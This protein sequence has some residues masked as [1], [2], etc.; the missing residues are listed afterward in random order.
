MPELLGDL[1]RF[2]IR[3]Q[4]SKHGVPREERRVSDVEVEGPPVATV[5]EK[6]GMCLGLVKEET[7]LLQG[8]PPARIAVALII[9]VLGTREDELTLLHVERLRDHKDVVA[10][11]VMN[12]HESTTGMLRHL[13]AQ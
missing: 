5:G 2:R 13:L 4:R 11:V 10:P 12:R 6:D 3:A 7:T 1:D 9:H 8:I